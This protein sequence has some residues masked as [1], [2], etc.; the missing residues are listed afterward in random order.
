MK[1]IITILIPGIAMAILW[2]VNSSCNKKDSGGSTGS[3]GTDS[4]LINIGNN[5]IIPAYQSLNTSVNTLDAAITDFNNSPDAS[6]LANVQALFKTAYIAWQSVSEYN[7]FGPAMNSQPTLAALNLFPA[8]ASKIDT[9]IVTGSYNVNV[10]SNSAAKGFPALDYLLF[11]AGNNTLANYTT[12]AQAASR[13]QYL[14]AVSADIK[15]EINKVTDSWSATGGNYINTFTTGTGNSISSSLG[16]LINS[17][18]QDLE[19]MKNDCF[20]IPLGKQP[21][22]TTLPIL[23][24]EVEAYYSGISIQLALAQLKAIQSIYLGSGGQGNG[25]G[26]INYLEKI[27]AQYNGG[28]LSDTIKAHFAQAVSLMQMVPDPLSATIQSNPAPANAVYTETQRLVVLLKTDMPSSLGVL[29][30][31]GD[32]DGD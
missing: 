21:P 17:M 18:D 31:Y 14:A 8:S 20:G 28:P 23:P 24:N 9:N 6:K 5:I 4:V 19:I 15:T 7:A 16:L 12:D 10:F 26:L 13:K 2:S 11:G 25:K 22:G 27:N 30:T 29:I 32:N 3:G 1:R